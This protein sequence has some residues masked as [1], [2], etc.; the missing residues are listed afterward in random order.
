M[1]EPAKVQAQRAQQDPAPST[2][3]PNRR[4]DWCAIGVHESD[5]KTKEC[6]IEGFFKKNQVKRA[7]P[8]FV[9]TRSDELS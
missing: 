7:N 1:D 3:K 9:V 8:I 6:L 2:P 5:F 4:T